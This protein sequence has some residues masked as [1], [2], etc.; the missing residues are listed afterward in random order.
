MKAIIAA[1]AI[2]ALLYRA[3]SHKS[4][5]PAGLVVAGLTAAAHAVH[6]WSLPFVLLGI[7][8]LLG[9][10]VTKVTPSPIPS[11]R[12]PSQ[13]LHDLANSLVQI[14]KDIKATLTVH[15]TG[16][17]GGEGPR[18]HVQVLANSLPAT[19]LTLLH[20]YTLY[21]SPEHCYGFGGLARNV[22]PIGIIANYAAVAADTFS[23]ELGILS[24]SLPRL[25]TSPT[26][27][28]V[29]KGTNGGVTGT[30]LL[31]GLLG[32]ALISAVGVALVPYCPIYEDATHGVKARSGLEGGYG[33]GIN[34]KTYLFAALT[35]WGALGSILDSILGGLFQA[36][37][38]DVRTGRV[39]EGDG[40]RTVLVHSAPRRGSLANLKTAPVAE[41]KAKIIEGRE[42]QGA[43]PKK[44]QERDEIF[45]ENKLGLVMPDGHESRALE[46][47]WGVLD[48]NEVNFI[49]AANMALGAMGL[50]AAYWGVEVPASLVG[51][52]RYGGLKDI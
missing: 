25:I 41:V 52:G 51:M 49:M 36:T 9:T 29:P 26:F 46:S 50:A 47:G 48:N 45:P 12:L 22:L 5:T 11:L 4:L 17:S 32:S 33:W 27:R 14:K 6:P 38:K 19:I 3:Y 30:G 18:N 7:F 43:V 39:I 21:H 31:A 44:V 2:A 10:K 42:G 23:S 35:I 28:R 13:S 40:G 34:E 15:S 8:F 1:P 16:G 37:V 24:N 20:A